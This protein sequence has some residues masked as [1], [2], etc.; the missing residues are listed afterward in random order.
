MKT[1]VVEY[2]DGAVSDDI[3]VVWQNVL[4]ALG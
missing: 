4:Y 2:T 1:S 3:K